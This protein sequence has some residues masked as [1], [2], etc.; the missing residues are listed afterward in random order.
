M[1]DFFCGGRISRYHTQTH[2]H[3]KNMEGEWGWEERQRDNIYLTWFPCEVMKFIS[4]LWEPSLFFLH[5]N[6][7]FAGSFLG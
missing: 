7:S 6:K 1:S 3:K 4:F 5:F 2:T